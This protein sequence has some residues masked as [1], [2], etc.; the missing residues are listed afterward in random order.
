MEATPTSNIKMVITVGCLVLFEAM[1][2]V[3]RPCAKCFQTLLK[4]STPFKKG[5][6][7]TQCQVL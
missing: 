1:K 4:G 6:A 3:S 2:A 5:Q 7:V